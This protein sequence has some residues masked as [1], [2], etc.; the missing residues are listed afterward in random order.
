MPI[1]RKNQV[2]WAAGFIDGEGCIGIY[3]TGA[4]AYRVSLSAGQKYN[5]E[6]LMRLQALF[7]GTIVRPKGKNRSYANAYWNLTSKRAT[8]A[9][10]EMLPFLTVKR[11]QAE[12]AIAFQSRRLVGSAHSRWNP[13]LEEHRARDHE[14]YV[15]ISQL[16]RK[17]GD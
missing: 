1:V 8:D 3:R 15:L 2:A 9:L 14:D 12:V 17:V 16:K 13:V 10:K 11:E 5:E 6:P 4:N 7:G